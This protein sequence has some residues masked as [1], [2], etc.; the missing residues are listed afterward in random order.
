MSGEIKQGFADYICEGLET[1]HSKSD[2]TK[3]KN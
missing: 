3:W 2:H 1:A